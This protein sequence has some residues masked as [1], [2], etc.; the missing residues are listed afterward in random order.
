MPSGWRTERTASV[1]PSESDD[2]LLDDLI[3]LPIAEREAFLDRTCGDDVARRQR[4]VGQMDELIASLSADICSTGELPARSSSSE[5]AHA[6]GAGLDLQEKP[7]T[8]I[9]RYILLGK[10]GEG[11][12][13]I[14]YR[15]EQRQPVRREVAL[16]L[17]KL[18]LDTREFVTRFEAERQALALMEH[19]NIARVFDAGAT[20]LGRPYFAMELVRGVPITRYCDEN[21]LPLRDRL[22][23]FVSVCQAVQHAHQK[24]VIHRDLKPS[25]I[26]VTLHDGAPVPKIIDFGIAKAMSAVVGDKTQFTQFHSFIGT[27]AYTSP[28]Q[29]EMS[30]LDVDTR[31]DVYSLGVLLYELLTGGT[32]FESEQLA[33]TGLDEMRKTVRETEPPRPSTRLSA[34]KQGE[35]EEIAHRRG[36]EP[37]KLV[38][39]LRGDLDWIAMKCLEKDRNRRYNT[40]SGLA[41]DVTRYLHDEP[42]I[43]RPPSAAYRFQKLVRRNKLAF[44]AGAAV[45]LALVAGLVTSSWQAM[46]AT[47]AERNA[48]KAQALS[49]H[50]RAAHEHA[51]PCVLPQWELADSP[52]VGERPLPDDELAHLGEIV[53]DPSERH[54]EPPGDVRHGRPLHEHGKED[55]DEHDPVEARGALDAREQRE[56]A[57]QDGDGPLQSAPRNED[58]LPS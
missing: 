54:A 55:D 11:G 50:V 46:R 3:D 14:V 18:G 51:E 41:A 35:L 58:A 23:L 31:S 56:R 22:H 6:L 19:P 57:E 12:C 28:E 44:I 21:K 10:I 2:P 30:G 8:I 43:A 49:T 20:P 25:N 24:G 9:G 1:K 37:P 38:H 48:V 29:L 39:R 33:R 13:G 16:K 47:R 42:V 45:S 17:I 40:A 27:P 7:G 52:A 4:L 5:I 34:M 26:L 36:I 15:A 32:P 53:V